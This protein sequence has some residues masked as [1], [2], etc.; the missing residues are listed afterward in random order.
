MLE[1]A[2]NVIANWQTRK[3][4]NFSRFPVFVWTITKSKRKNW[5]IKVHCLKFAS[6]L[7]QNAHFWHELVDLTFCGQSIKSHD[8]SHNGLQHVTD[9][10]HDE[11]L[12]FMI[13]VITANVVM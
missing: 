9:D 12:T 11:S 4:S 6:I 3:R 5:K 1:N 8:L 13:Q 7:F 10:W 2:W